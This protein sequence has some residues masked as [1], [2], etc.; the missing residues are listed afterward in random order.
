MKVQTDDEARG[1]GGTMPDHVLG[2]QTPPAVRVRIQGTCTALLQPA[3]QFPNQRF[4]GSARDKL[5]SR[6]QCLDLEFKKI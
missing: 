6:R 2:Q 5:Q 3:D 4:K 1:H